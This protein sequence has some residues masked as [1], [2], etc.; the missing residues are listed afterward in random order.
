M[1]VWP[2]GHA[3]QGVPV[4]RPD[5][6]ALEVRLLERLAIRFRPLPRER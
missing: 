2:T 4:S 1:I 3:D 6:A 5:L